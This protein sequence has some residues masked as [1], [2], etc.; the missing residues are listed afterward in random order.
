MSSTDLLRTGG[1]RAEHGVYEGQTDG[2]GAM[3]CMATVEARA[4]GGALVRRPACRTPLPI[5]ARK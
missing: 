1:L 4:V 2:T 3:R 5:S